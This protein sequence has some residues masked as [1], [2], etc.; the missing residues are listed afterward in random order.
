MVQELFSPSTK[1]VRLRSPWLSSTIAVFNLLMECMPLYSPSKHLYLRAFP[2]QRHPMWACDR[3][4]SDIVVQLVASAAL[5]Q[6]SCPTTSHSKPLRLPTPNIC[7]QLMLMALNSR[8][9]MI[10]APLQKARGRQTA[11]LTAGEQRAREAAWHGALQISLTGYCTALA[12]VER[13]TM[14]CAVQPLRLSSRSV[15]LHEGLA[16]LNSDSGNARVE[17]SGFYWRGGTREAV[18]NVVL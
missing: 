12:V 1:R 15:L 4:H 14:C 3:C 9:R 13:A 17:R 8:A 7:S 10:A 16:S 5:H 2:V 11:R 6:S 18:G